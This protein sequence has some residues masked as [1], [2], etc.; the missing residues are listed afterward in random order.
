MKF[1]ITAKSINKDNIEL[2]VA[3]EDI[4][5]FPRPITK[6]LSF[7]DT[8]TIEIPETKK[9][10]NNPMNK[11]TEIKEIK[12]L[13]LCFDCKTPIYDSGQ[14]NLTKIEDK[15]KAICLRCAKKRLDD[16]NLSKPDKK[17][18]I[19]DKFCYQCGIALTDLHITTGEEGKFMCQRCFGDNKSPKKS[20]CYKC[21]VLLSGTCMFV[22]ACDTCKTLEDKGKLKDVFED[23]YEQ[24]KKKWEEV[25][26]ISKGINKDKNLSC[27]RCYGYFSNSEEKFL[28]G[29]QV[30]CKQCYKLRNTPCNS[31][32]RIPPI[33]NDIDHPSHYNQGKI[34]I[35]DFI[36]DQKLGFHENNIIKYVCRARHKGTMLKD[37]KKAQWY[38][39]RYIEI[40]QDVENADI[41]AERGG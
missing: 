6:V 7:N 37:L 41:A 9:E 14:Y 35:I 28:V 20:N 2:T 8:L 30:Y 10:W 39:Q 27:T 26:D 40:I 19:Q 5:I 22:G 36:E 13:G 21:G 32:D 25:V 38:L 34:E 17:E 3:S 1:K 33:K 16:S 4:D 23:I 11:N 31:K 24:N 18:T 29:S 15:A 12:F